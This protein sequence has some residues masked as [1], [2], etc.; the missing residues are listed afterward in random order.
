MAKEHTDDI[1]LSELDALRAETPDDLWS[2]FVK[3]INIHADPA[4]VAGGDNLKQTKL[5]DAIEQ[6]VK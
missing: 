4:N 3:A 5:K 2:L 1:D 6:L